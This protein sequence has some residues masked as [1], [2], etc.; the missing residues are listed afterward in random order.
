MNAIRMFAF[1]AAVL[2]R[3]AIDQRRLS[4]DQGW[5]LAIFACTVV[6]G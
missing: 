3:V 1:I 4:R 5:F 6:L 2:F